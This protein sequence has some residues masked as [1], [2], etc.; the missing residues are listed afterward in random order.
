M[1]VMYSQI[2]GF[3]EIFGYDDPNEIIGQPLS[4]TVHPDDLH[5][6]SELNRLR[7]EGESVTSRYEFRGIKKDGTVRIIEVSAAE[8]N[9]LGESVSLAY[10]Q[11]Y[12]GL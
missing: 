7:Q 11:G 4:V 2:D 3:A 8:S 1:V 10:L 12:Y 5:M 6:V 9:Y